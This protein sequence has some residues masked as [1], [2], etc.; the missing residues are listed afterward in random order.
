MSKP[1]VI[2]DVEHERVHERVAAID[3]A[4]ATGI[5]CLRVPGQSRSGR[6]RSMVW[7]VQA[8]MPAVGE[9]AA[10]LEREMVQMVTMEAASDY[11]RVWVRREAHCR[12]ARSAGGNWR[13]CSWI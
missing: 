3:V 6:R 2:E 12:M 5:V 7:Q 10:A 8:S 13:R 11:W 1:Q 4:K 9:L